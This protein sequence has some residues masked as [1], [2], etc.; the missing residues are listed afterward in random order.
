MGQ[1]IRKIKERGKSLFKDVQGKGG[2]KRPLNP[3]DWATYQEQTA[4]DMLRKTEE[5]LKQNE[6]FGEALA[7]AVPVDEESLKEAEEMENSKKLD[8][9]IEQQV[10]EPASLKKIWNSFQGNEIQKEKYIHAGLLLAAY[11]ALDEVIHDAANPTKLFHYDFNFEKKEIIFE[12]AKGKNTKNGINITALDVLFASNLLGDLPVL[13]EGRT[14][15]G[16][17]FWA[18]TYLNTFLG[19]ENYAVFK[20]NNI[21]TNPLEVITKSE[22]YNGGLPIDV[23]RKELM[24]RLGA[25]FVDELNRGDTNVLFDLSQGSVNIE[26]KKYPLGVIIPQFTEEGIVF[27]KNRRKFFF[28]GAQNPPPSK[29]PKY[30][31]TEEID[32][33]LYNR[34]FVIEFEDSPRLTGAAVMGAKL[35]DAL[36][37]QF[38]KSYG[39]YIKKILDVSVSAEDIEQDRLA[40]YAF[41]TDAE[42]TK[43]HIVKF[44]REFADCL[45]F[46]L[47]SGL[48]DVVREGCE[49]MTA[50]TALLKD[51]YEL[52]LPN[53]EFD[54]EKDELKDLTENCNGYDWTTRDVVYIEKYARFISTIDVLKSALNEENPL[55]ALLDDNQAYLVL[56]EHMAAATII[57]GQCRGTDLSEGVKEVYQE[58]IS[59]LYKHRK[60]KFT[61][62]I[63]QGIFKNSLKESED[64]YSA[65]K[66]ICDEINRIYY[67]SESEIE[68]LIHLR[69]TR[70][71]IEL[72]DF[73]EL[74]A[75]E[76]DNIIK[77]H[78]DAD[79]R[80]SKLGDLYK[81]KT[82]NPNIK[83]KYKEALAG[84]YF[85]CL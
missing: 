50:I 44:S 29:D 43:R 47:G 80:L 57:N 79:A 12:K 68:K 27:D 64:T 74:Y 40:H 33:A 17:T 3:A 71:L 19:K 10:K 54:F 8:E 73:L 58:Y 82:E 78:S 22:S 30:N 46:I 34:F 77:E 24:D 70:N 48:Q 23:P 55:K 5:L 69:H 38:T 84:W 2:F 13:F 65:I 85:E 20:F 72:I 45:I 16:K 15:G 59:V 52:D 75:D 39:K 36:D 6:E 62:G 11:C 83:H 53:F 18:E 60:G 37:K 67:N 63:K 76:C 49:D 4:E 61:E 41:I 28:I 21:R 51:K 35:Q 81:K 9:I 1:L 14:G 32:F 66:S 42:K 56:P 25:F 26:G 7:S 31:G